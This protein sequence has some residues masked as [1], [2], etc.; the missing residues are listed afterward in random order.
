MESVLRKSHLEF[1]GPV[2]VLVSEYMQYLQVRLDFHRSHPTI[3]CSLKCPENILEVDIDL[4]YNTLLDFESTVHQISVI[5]KS[6][7][8]RLLDSKDEIFLIFSILIKDTWL[9]YQFLEICMEKLMRGNLN[10]LTSIK[11]IFSDY[12][13]IFYKFYSDCEQLEEIIKNFNIP[14]LTIEPTIF[15][16]T[17]NVKRYSS[18]TSIQYSKSVS[19]A[20]SGKHLMINSISDYSKSECSDYHSVVDPSYVKEKECDSVDIKISNIFTP[21]FLKTRP[22]VKEPEGLDNPFG[23]NFQTDLAEDDTQTVQGSN[24]VLFS[25]YA[26]KI[27]DRQNSFTSNNLLD[28]SSFWKSKYEKSMYELNLLKMENELL[29]SQ[30][31]EMIASNFRSM[32][33]S[34][35]NI[36]VSSLTSQATGVHSQISNENSIFGVTGATVFPNPVLASGST[37][38]MTPTAGPN[39]LTKL[40]ITSNSSTAP[41][42]ATQSTPSISGATL[43]N[44][45]PSA[46][47]G[48]SNLSTYS[49]VELNSGVFPKPSQNNPFIPSYNGHAQRFPTRSYT[50]DTGTLNQEV[51]QLNYF[52][53]GMNGEVRP[54]LFHD[55]KFEK[56][57]V[58]NPFI[59]D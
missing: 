19:N 5:S 33:I 22:V 38:L 7:L 37:P 36:P 6:M 8:D 29:K 16:R 21:S 17:R 4:C 2:G 3:N 51:R 34:N 14:K 58:N 1:H 45:I 39:S 10:D 42:S 27:T 43:H 12:H 40:D 41:K 28:D 56:T 46:S 57:S 35:P 59:R 26:T 50:I 23:D 30:M 49:Q 55:N 31:Q 47:N 53:N 20:T 11:Q 9:V 13:Q 24:D 54:V 15:S 32:S 48:Y 52:P 18:T 25:N 44:P